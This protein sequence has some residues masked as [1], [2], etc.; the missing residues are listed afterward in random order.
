MEDDGH[1]GPGRNQGGGEP[2]RAQRKGDLGGG[3]RGAGQAPAA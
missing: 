2:C 1:R 3:R